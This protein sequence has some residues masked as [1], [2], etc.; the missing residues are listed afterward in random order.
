MS[1]RISKTAVTE[2]Q[3]EPGIASALAA[4]PRFG[5]KVIESNRILSEAVT[6]VSTWRNTGRQLRLEATAL[7]TCASTFEHP[8]MDE[9]RRLAAPS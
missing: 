6:A 1:I 3:E 2:D 7:D 9:A 8:L 4:A 5:L